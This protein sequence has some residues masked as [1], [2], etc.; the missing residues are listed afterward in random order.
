MQ[1]T[2]IFGIAAVPAIMGLVEAA[3]TAGLPKN[4]APLAAVLLGIGAGILSHSAGSVGWQEAIAGGIALG[5]AASGL[6]SGGK[7][8]G[9]AIKLR[10]HRNQ[11]RKTMR[12]APTPPTDGRTDN[13][14]TARA[15]DKQRLKHAQALMGRERAN[16][17]TKGAVHGA[18]TS[19]D[20]GPGN[21]TEPPQKV[22]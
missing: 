12:Q 16:R 22:T 14:P 20:Q 19:P 11:A 17:V 8:V 3:T 9:G 5:L 2:T 13:L 18:G 6:Y 15:I 1:T 10:Y 4:L 7:Q 21:T